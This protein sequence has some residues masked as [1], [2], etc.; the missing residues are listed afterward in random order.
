MQGLM[1][2]LPHLIAVVFLWAVTIVGTYAVERFIKSKALKKVGVKKKDIK[3]ILPFIPLI[4][5]GATAIAVIVGVAVI[6][7]LYNPM[8]RTY[9]EMDKMTE[10]QS[11]TGH[12]EATK[13]EIKEQNKV[14]AAAKSKKL[15]KSA[16]EDTD[17]AMDALRS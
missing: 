4:R 6:L 11:D 5:I 10:A 8:V 3:P 7:F 2:V 15:K 9:S 13:E 1:S 17:K 12:V 16:E 14:A